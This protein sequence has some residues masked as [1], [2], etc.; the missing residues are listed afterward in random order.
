[1]TGTDVEIIE[2]AE[3]VGSVQAGGVFAVRDPREMIAQATEIANLLKDVVRQAGLVKRIKDKDYLLAEAWT[4]LG[5]LVGCTARTEWTRPIEGGWEAAVEVVNANGLVISRAEAECLRSESLWR[6]RDD[7]AIRSMSQTRAMGK[8]LRMPLGW[9]AVLAGY[10]ATPG[11]EMPEPSLTTP[12]VSNPTSQTEHRTDGKRPVKPAENWV[13]WEQRMTN[14]GVSEP[15]EWLKQAVVHL[16]GIDSLQGITGPQRR[17]LLAKANTVLV[18]L[19]EAELPPDAQT[20]GFVPDPM[21]AEAWAHVLEGAVLAGP[22]SASI[23][24]GDA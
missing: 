23:P 20:L 24:F 4:T 13:E 21:V 5:V 7:Y 6:N 16:H 11:D 3:I 12:G 2:D 15:N 8:A 17:T 10:E 1:M 22:E 18:N 19:T 9:I 14:L